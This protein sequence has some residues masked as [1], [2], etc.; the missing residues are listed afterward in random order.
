MKKI[1]RM[2]QLAG[3]LC[4]IGMA[5][6]AGS[7]AMSIADVSGGV[8]LLVACAGLLCLANGVRINIRLATKVMRCS[9]R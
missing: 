8:V 5:A 6:V 9:L 7:A 4:F 2:R 1:Y 3:L